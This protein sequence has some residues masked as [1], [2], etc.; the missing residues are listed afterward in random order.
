VNDELAEQRAQIY[1]E[2]AFRSLSELVARERREHRALLETKTM[3][4]LSRWR[5]TYGWLRN[6]RRRSS[7][8]PTASGPVDPIPQDQYQIWIDAFDT[9]DSLARLEIRDRVAALDHSPLISVVMS[10]HDTPEDFLRAAVM[11]VTEQLYENWELCIADDASTIGHVTD[12][13][14]E[15]RSADPRIKVVRRAENGGICAATNS[16]LSLAEG[17]WVAFLDHDD[18]IPEHA[19]ALAVVALAEQPGAG[20]LYTDEDKLDGHGNRHSPYFKPDFDPLLLLGQNYLTHFLLVRR[21]LV[22]AVGGIRP[23][24]EGSQDWDLALR[25]TERIEPSQVVH[26]PHILY[27]WRSHT[28]S[29]SAAL[30]A[31]P[32]AADAGRRA[33]EEHLSRSGRGAVVSM[34]PSG[35]LRVTWDLPDEP[36]LVSVVIPTR[37][38]KLLRQCIDSLLNKTD[39]PHLEVMVVDN[40][41]RDPDVLAYLRDRQVDVQVIRDE[42]PFNYAAL[43]NEAVKQTN[44]EVV[45]LLNDDTEV[46]EGCWL[47]DMV[48]QLCQPD[49]GAVGAKLYY[50]DGTIQH[51]GVVLGIGGVGGHAYRHV[52]GESTGSMGRLM[53]AQTMTAV[54]GACMAVRRRAWEELGGM[55]EVNL[56][57]AFNDVDFCLRLREGGWKVVW[58]PEAKLIHHESITRGPEIHRRAGFAAEGR[59]I[60]RRWGDALHDDPAYNPNLSTAAEDFSLA[61][62]PRVSYR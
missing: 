41:S 30:A 33:V 12:V 61:W 34:L 37:D 51:G 3:R 26:V 6:L 39:Y 57:I 58:T 27:H 22:A 45:C 23:G 55:D 19:L 46:I 1:S 8:P 7:P 5:D 17:E 32:Y 43:N 31:K 21:D 38:G 15:L 40:G 13:L 4:Y 44:G 62:P 11:S 16:A 28:G 48:R 49:V 25:V 9:V 56:P 2:R 10:V 18:V 60:L 47:E 52:S 14:E 54:T 20:L 29:T 53:L 50:S 42:R 59:Y 24:F 36:P 35:H